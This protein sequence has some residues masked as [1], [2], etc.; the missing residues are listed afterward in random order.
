MSMH[1]NDTDDTVRCPS[2]A[3]KQALVDGARDGSLGL[4]GSPFN[5][6]VEWMME[7]ARALSLFS[8]DGGFSEHP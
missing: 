8:Q 6:Q 4:W 7:P 3:M 2:A 5:M 1:T